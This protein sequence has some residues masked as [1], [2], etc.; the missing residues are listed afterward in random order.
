MDYSDV[1]IKFA[2]RRSLLVGRGSPCMAELDARLDTCGRKAAVLWV[3]KAVQS[4]VERLKDY[5]PGDGRFEEAVALSRLWAEGK[6]KMPAARR[7]IL[8]AHAAAK[9]TNDIV[10][11]SLCHAVGQACSAVHTPR[12]AVGL[13]FYELTAM[14]YSCGMENFEDGADKK[15]CCYLALLDRVEEEA[16]KSRPWASFIK[17]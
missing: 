1:Y 16:K 10:A 3:L 11:N 5:F 4:P 17:N 8:R 7:A 14:A 12:H 2:K 6:I 15:I 13:A 9:Q